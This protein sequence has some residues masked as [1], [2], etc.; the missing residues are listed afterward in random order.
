MF[1]KS[2]IWLVMLTLAAAI[3][4][5]A[6]LAAGETD[7]LL[8]NGSFETY[9]KNPNTWTMAGHVDLDL[10]IGN[11][12]ITGWTVIRGMIDYFGV[13]PHDPLHIWNAADGENSIELAVSPSA[14]GVSQTFATVAS[15]MYRVQFSMSGSPMTGWSGEDIPNRTLRAQAAG[16]SADFVYDVAAEQ[17]SYSDMK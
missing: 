8:Q 10:G 12:D 1:K 9:T 2:K 14:G 15:E 4:L 3:T 7:N 11:T 13:C 17:N 5:P 6:Y 16:Q